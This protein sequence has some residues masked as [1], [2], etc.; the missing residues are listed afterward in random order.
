LVIGALTDVT[1]AVKDERWL[2]AEEA[3]GVGAKSE[4]IVVAGG[5]VAVVPEALH[6]W[7]I[8]RDCNCFNA[9]TR[10]HKG[11]TDTARSWYQAWTVTI[12]HALGIDRFQH[13]VT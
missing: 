6:D 13:I 1:A 8:A 2:P 4:G 5:G 12:G 10:S 7:K 11:S 3:G 9:K